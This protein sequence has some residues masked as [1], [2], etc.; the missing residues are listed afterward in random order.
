M[1]TLVHLPFSRFDYKCS[2]WL[3]RGCDAR[4]S[5]HHHHRDG[6]GV[7]PS[8]QRPAGAGNA[9][10]GGDAERGGSTLMLRRAA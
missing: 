8:I 10:T 6:G 3:G 9:F 7:D 1:T 5:D 2:Q 4:L